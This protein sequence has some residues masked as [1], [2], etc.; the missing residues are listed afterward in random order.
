ME[1]LGSRIEM[2]LKV[3]TEQVWAH[4]PAQF[5]FRTV[6]DCTDPAEGTAFLFAVKF[7]QNDPKHS[8]YKHKKWDFNKYSNIILFAVFPSLYFCFSGERLSSE[9]KS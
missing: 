7:L 1:A 3:S 9:Q 5:S 2:G 6:N 4:T 8:M